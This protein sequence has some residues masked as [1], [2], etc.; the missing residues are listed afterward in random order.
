MLKSSKNVET[1]VYSLEIEISKETFTAALD[2]AFKKNKSKIQLPGFRKGKATRA[3]VESFYGKGYFYEDALDLCFGEAVMSASE[4]AGLEVVGT[5][6]ADITE[7]SHNGVQMTVEV[8]VKPEIEVSAYKEL[9]ATKKKVEVTDEEIDAKIQQ[10]VE[11]NARVISVEDRAVENGDITIIDFEGFLDGVAFEGGKGEN[12]ELEIGSGSFVPGF[13]EQLVGHAIGE[14]FD[15]DVT[16][17]EQ[18]HEGLAGKAVVFKIKINEIKTKQYP[19]VDDEFAQDAADYDTV[20]A[21]K[22][23][24]AAEIKAAKEADNARDIEGQL[25]EKLAEN[26]EGEIPEVMYE[27]EIDNQ[28]RDLDYRFQM[29]GMNFAT[30]LQYTG[31]SMEDYRAQMKEGA[32]KNVKVRLALEKIAALEALEVTDEETEA[33]YAK[34]AAQYNMEVD[35]IKEVVAVETL[36]ADM[37]KEKAIKFVVDNAKVT[38]QR[39]PRAKKEEAPADAE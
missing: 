11:R 18:Y 27:N 37:L 8:F 6:N 32:V 19:E 20:E 14:E 26:V 12:Y 7:I 34:F 23:G 36:K 33:E 9:K 2:K 4:E 38:T 13:E 3:V 30:Y 5:K 22:K 24:F 31:M 16:F 39:K 25:L 29:Q 28:I 21:M 1:N 10:L 17:P 35:K 15:I